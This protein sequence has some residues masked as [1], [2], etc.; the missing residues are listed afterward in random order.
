MRVNT[1]SLAGADWL[2]SWNE[3]LHNPI[4]CNLWF[5]QI[6]SAIQYLMSRKKSLLG[7]L[8]TKVTLINLLYRL[9]FSSDAYIFPPI[10]CINKLTQRSPHGG[11]A[12][13]KPF[14]QL[15]ASSSVRKKWYL[16]STT[17][18]PAISKIGVAVYLESFV[19]ICHIWWQ[20]A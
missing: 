12:I 1:R 13:K 16:S 8:F 3:F 19:H 18:L 6:N 2:F 4:K 15:K 10:S 14:F 5:G 9:L 11:S 7:N 20:Q 17:F